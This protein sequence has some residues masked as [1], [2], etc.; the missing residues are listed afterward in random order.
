MNTKIQK[1][2]RKE[3]NIIF[4]YLYDL[5]RFNEYT[6]GYIDSDYVYDVIDKEI[7]VQIYY[8]NTF[9]WK[10]PISVARLFQ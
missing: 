9:G 2:T 3:I 4:G 1:L 6:T 8:E 5:A 7:Q 10:L